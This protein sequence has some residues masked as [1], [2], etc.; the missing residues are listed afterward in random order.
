MH[1]ITLQHRHIA[2]GLWHNTCMLLHPSTD[3]LPTDY[4]TSHARYDTLASTHC[5]RTKDVDEMLT[6]AVQSH[7]LD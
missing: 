6:V 7:R 4:G 1:A 2:N 5:P 3:T